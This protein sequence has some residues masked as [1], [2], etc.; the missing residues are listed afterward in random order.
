M[1]FETYKETNKAYHEGACL[2]F[3]NDQWSIAAC[4]EDDGG[5]PHGRW[6]FPQIK[7]QPG[8]KAIPV[9]VTIGQSKDEAIATL[10]RFIRHL[11][12]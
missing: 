9:K 3:Y 7:D 6:A 11:K 8:S 5:T 10:E 1:L 4:R 2:D 12:G